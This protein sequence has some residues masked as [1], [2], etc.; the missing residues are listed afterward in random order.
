MDVDVE[1]CPEGKVRRVQSIVLV[2]DEWKD[3]MFSTIVEHLV[4]S[5][6]IVVFFVWIVFVF[7][8]G[9]VLHIPTYNGLSI[10]SNQHPE[11]Y[12]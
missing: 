8:R 1:N 7:V 4:E 9:T 5:S 3:P 11:Q 6:I 2:S 10:G 12:R